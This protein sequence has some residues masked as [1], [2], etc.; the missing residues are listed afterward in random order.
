MSQESLQA[1]VEAQVAAVVP[2]AL[3]RIEAERRGL[4]R[5]Y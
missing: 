1:A 5:F 3:A 2:G 4:Q